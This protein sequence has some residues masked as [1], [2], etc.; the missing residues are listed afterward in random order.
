LQTPHASGAAPAAAAAA[1]AA[2]TDGFSRTPLPRHF[3]QRAA[4]ACAASAKD[5]AEEEVPSPTLTVGATEVA[6]DD[7]S[8]AEVGRFNASRRGL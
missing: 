4:G 7:F 1:G 2:P 5:E 8:E 3:Q 6:I